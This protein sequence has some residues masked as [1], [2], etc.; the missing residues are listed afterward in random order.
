MYLTVEDGEKIGLS[1]SMVHALN[2]LKDA[3]GAGHH[4]GGEKDIHEMTGKAL[5]RR[6]LAQRSQRDRDTFFLT[7]EGKRLFDEV[8]EERHGDDDDVRRMQNVETFTA[9]QIRNMLKDKGHRRAAQLV[10]DW[11]A[12]DV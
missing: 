12:G 1:G 2:E 6:G 5:E 11:M 9:H 3:F 7:P 4:G 10:G 8:W